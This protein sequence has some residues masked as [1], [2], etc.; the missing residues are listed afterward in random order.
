MCIFNST[1]FTFTPMHNIS[2]CESWLMHSLLANFLGSIHA[3]I[4]DHLG[5]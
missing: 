2:H 5:D 3:A 4:Y 1:Y